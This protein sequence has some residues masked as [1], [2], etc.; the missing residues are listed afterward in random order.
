MLFPPRIL[1]TS[2]EHLLKQLFIYSVH[3]PAKF[4]GNIS[5]HCFLTSVLSGSLS[6][7]FGTQSDAI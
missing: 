4:H 6:F 3:I 1:D 7:L 5:I 2:I